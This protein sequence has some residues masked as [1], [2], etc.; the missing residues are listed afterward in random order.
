MA[1]MNTEPHRIVG[2]VD[3]PIAQAKC[4]HCQQPFKGGNKGDPGVNV[5]SNDGLREV[6]ISGVCEAC[7]DGMFEEVDD[8]D[9][10]EFCLGCADEPTVS[11]MDAGRCDCCGKALA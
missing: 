9:D 3:T 11:E 2:R 6:R 10:S 5:Y 1:A 8:E 7:F 4:L